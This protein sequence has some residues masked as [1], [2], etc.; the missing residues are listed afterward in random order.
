[1]FGPRMANSLFGAY[2][3][4]IAASDA[5]SLDELAAQI[6]RDER[7]TANQLEAL[8]IVFH[9]RLQLDSDAPSTTNAAKL[10][11]SKAAAAL[12]FLDW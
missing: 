2:A 7:L 4:L 9:A 6:E 8:K 11:F 5:G 10:S 12:T 1:M 3:F